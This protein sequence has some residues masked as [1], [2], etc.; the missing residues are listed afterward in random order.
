M[1]KYQAKGE[2]CTAA[3]IKKELER[4]AYESIIYVGVETLEYLKRSGG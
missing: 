1:S 3:E 4:S 2:G